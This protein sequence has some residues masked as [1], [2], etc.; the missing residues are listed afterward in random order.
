MNRSRLDRVER[1]LRDDWPPLTE[2]VTDGQIQAA[3]ADLEADLNRTALSNG[4]P[5]ERF[6]ARC[7]TTIERLEKQGLW[8]RGE[9]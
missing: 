2:E 7:D 5:V 1:A 9:L 6:L 3:I 8:P 4:E